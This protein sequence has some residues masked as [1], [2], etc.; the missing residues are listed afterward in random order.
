MILTRKEKEDLVI[1]FA[2]QGKSSR[3]IAKAVHI[4]LKDIGA[5]I[6][7]HTG[8]ENN[9]EIDKSLLSINSKAFKILK[10]NKSLIDVAHH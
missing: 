3:H 10:E 9:I 5:I 2:N 1:K 6:R 4:S 7:R 8:E